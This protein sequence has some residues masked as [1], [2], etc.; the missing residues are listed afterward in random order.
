MRDDHIA[1]L[2]SRLDHE[3]KKWLAEIKVWSSFGEV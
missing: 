2:V 3:K 1:E